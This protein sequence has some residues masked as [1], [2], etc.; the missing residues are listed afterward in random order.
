MEYRTSHPESHP[1]DTADPHNDLDNHG[2]IY[3]QAHVQVSLH[4]YNARPVNV[5][6]PEIFT[7]A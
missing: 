4:P 2:H 5:L 1:A 3:I 7:N 6:E